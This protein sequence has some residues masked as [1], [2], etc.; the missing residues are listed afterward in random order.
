M[1]MDTT[2]HILNPCPGG[3]IH[4]TD[5]LLQQSASQHHDSMDLQ[6]QQRE[7]TVELLKRQAKQDKEFEIGM[8]NLMCGKAEEDQRVMASVFCEN[9][10]AL[11]ESFSIIHEMSQTVAAY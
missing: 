10:K 8:W 6:W 4:Q 3:T 1:E 9:P 11:Q 5:H 2:R 7:A